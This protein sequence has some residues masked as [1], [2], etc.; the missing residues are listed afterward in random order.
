MNQYPCASR[1]SSLDSEPLGAFGSRRQRCTSRKG[2]SVCS[3]CTTTSL[4]ACR[5]RA[6]ES[7]REC[8]CPR[9]SNASSTRC[10]AC[11]MSPRLLASSPSMPRICATAKS[12]FGQFGGLLERASASSYCPR[13][14]S[15]SPKPSAMRYRI[16]LDASVAPR[17]AIRYCS[18]RNLQ[19]VLVPRLLGSVQRVGQGHFAAHQ[20][21]RSDM[22]TR[23]RGAVRV[24]PGRRRLQDA[25]AVGSRAVMRIQTGLDESCRG[26]TRSDNRQAVPTPTCRCRASSK[27]A[28]ASELS[29]GSGWQ[30][31]PGQILCPKWPPPAAFLVVCCGNSSMRRARIEPAWSEAE[32]FS[33]R[34]VPCPSRGASP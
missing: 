31:R 22:P 18:L 15:T 24:L 33:P 26:R 10:T 12:P 6:A 16:D 9:A 21:H 14:M 1:L 5:I 20:R 23:R 28:N 2:K 27:A 34:V 11:P 25:V 30:P 3:N 8:L 4:A 7:A 32:L 29:G 13:S 17:S 19:C